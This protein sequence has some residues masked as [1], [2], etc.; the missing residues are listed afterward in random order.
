MLQ[1]VGRYADSGIAD[2]YHDTVRC[3]L[4]HYGDRS[5][6]RRELDR[7]RDE[8]E[9]YLSELARICVRYETRICLTNVKSQTFL[10]GFMRNH[11]LDRSEC[12]TN[13][14]WLQRKR[15]SPRLHL[16]EAEYV[17][18][19]REKMSLTLADAIEYSPLSLGKR[20]IELEQ[21][22]LYVTHDRIEW[23][24]EL[25]THYCEKS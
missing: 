20:T 11:R 6:I 9:K 21:K 5:A 7:V 8:V 2:F 25:V 16:C 18:D 24:A 23:R 4:R 10:R 14:Y 22:E 12:I 1:V 13:D 15:Q 17:F 3:R 19:Q